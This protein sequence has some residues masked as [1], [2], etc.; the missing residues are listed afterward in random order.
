[1]STDMLDPN[2]LAE[3]RLNNCGRVNEISRGLCIL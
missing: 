3:I 1:M 2:V